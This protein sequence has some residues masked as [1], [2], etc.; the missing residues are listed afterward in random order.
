MSGFYHL[1]RIWCIAMGWKDTMTVRLARHTPLQLTRHHTGRPTLVRRPPRLLV[2]PVFILCS[3]RSGST[4]LRMILNSHSELYAPHELHLSQLKVTMGNRYVTDA[5]TE[6][7][8][9][10]Q[11]L[12]HL[13]WDRVLDAALA[14]SGKR[15]LVEKTPHH[16][17]MWSRIARCWPD[18][19][20]IFLLRDPAAICDSWH[21]ARPRQTR[22]ELLE[23]VGKYTGA[24]QAARRTLPGHTIRYE[25]LVADPEAQVRRVCEY[26]RVPFEPGMI[27][28]GER[29]H[30]PIKPGLGDWTERIRTGRVQPPRQVTPGAELSPALAAIARDWGY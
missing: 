30:G 17:F 2:A 7:G 9:T 26:L 8:W 4:L 14:R 29:H 22:G 28:Y 3:V 12:T 10:E 18:A 24:V 6:L 13:L 27:E 11:E 21:R 19:R 25:D 23:R 16:A 5:M 15:T 1:E 20:F